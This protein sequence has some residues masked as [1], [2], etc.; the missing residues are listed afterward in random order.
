MDEYLAQQLQIL[1]VG[2]W[3]ES[4]KSADAIVRVGEPAVIPMIQAL[5]DSPFDVFE[6]TRWRIT[7]VLGRLG[8]TR[9]VPHLIPLLASD[10][11]H[12]RQEVARALGKLK[13]ERAIAPLIDTFRREEFFDDDEV[14][15]ITGWEVAAEALAEFEGAA[16]PSLIEA[17]YDS[18]GNVRAWA[19]D[20]LRQIRDARAVDPLI[21]VLTDRE[22][23]V[24]IDSALALGAI[25][26]ARAIAPLISVLQH[27][28][29]DIVRYSAASALGELVHG[30]VLE[31]LVHA[32]YDPVS[33]VRIAAIVAL[34]K[35]AG[36]EVLQLIL[37][38]LH[39]P[40]ACVRSAACHALAAIGDE[41]AIPALE[42]VIEH[43][44][45]RYRAIL[46]RGSAEYA[47]AS[48]KQKRER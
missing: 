5:E 20:A 41:R 13:D 35:S 32:V 19:A 24:R 8:D 34:A 3:Q 30:E 27:D 33:D 1:V 6:H 12:L 11:P 7:D 43:D 22:V 42:E 18:H 4:A 21:H 29:N 44:K 15:A 14:E 48:I 37:N 40:D 39:D 36:V 46:V 10:N 31:P 28:D 16:V 2:T 47:I 23:Q 17:L 9:A 45:G 38:L 26:D 25:G